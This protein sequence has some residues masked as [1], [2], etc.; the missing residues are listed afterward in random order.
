MRIGHQI[1]RSSQDKTSW[2]ATWKESRQSLNQLAF[3]CSSDVHV[4]QLPRVCLARVLEA[5]PRICCKSWFDGPSGW[6]SSMGT[7]MKR[8]QPRLQRLQRGIA[9]ATS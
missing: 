1:S 3:F 2:R 5:K 8:L 7:C 9:T 4:F 6:L